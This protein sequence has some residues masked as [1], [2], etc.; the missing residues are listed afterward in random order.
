MKPLWGVQSFE[1]PRL[2]HSEVLFLSP[3]FQ[4]TRDDIIQQVMHLALVLRLI[5]DCSQLISWTFTVTFGSFD[6]SN[7]RRNLAKQWYTQTQAIKAA[8]PSPL[9]LY[10]GPCE[11]RNPHFEELFWAENCKKE[12]FSKTVIYA[13][14]LVGWLIPCCIILTFL[15]RKHLLSYFLDF[16]G[17]IQKANILI[18]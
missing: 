13:L 15:T 14:A 2:F 4:E 16:M 10:W 17:N 12:K 11:A 9:A 8:L 7:R 5:P 3:Y 1:L 18:F 6:E